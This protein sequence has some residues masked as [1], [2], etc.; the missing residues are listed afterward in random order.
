M[1]KKDWK[2]QLLRVKQLAD[3]NLGRSEK[4][5][6]LTDDLQLLER[7]INQIKDAW[8]MIVKK[9]QACLI[10]HSGEAEKRLR[11][12]PEYAFSSCLG[13]LAVAFNNETVLGKT[14]GLCSEAQMFLA[15]GSVHYTMDIEA[16]VIQP[17]QVLVDRDIPAILKLR[18]QLAN[19]TLDMDSAKS[20]YQAL[21][22]QSQNAS[23]SVRL[24]A[25]REEF[26]E[27]EAKVEHCKDVLATEMYSFFAREEELC[28]MLLSLLES[29]LVFHQHSI[30]ALDRL[31]PLVKEEIEMMAT[32]PVFGCS[33]EEHLRHSKR[34]VASVIEECAV[35][36]IR[37]GLDV[38]G[39]FRIAPAA[40]KVKKL[41]AAFDAN[42]VDLV[43][44]DDIHCFSAAL[45]HYLRELPEP[46]MTF[47]LYDEWLQAS[48]RPS[49]ERLNALWVVIDKLPKINCLHLRYLIKFLTKVTE[50]SDV[51]KMN[52]SNLGIVIGPNLLW[53]PGDSRRDIHH[54][55]SVALIVE[56]LISSSEWFFPG[57]L[58]FSPAGNL[59]LNPTISSSTDIVSQK[60]QVKIAFLKDSPNDN[61]SA[62]LPTSHSASSLLEQ[63]VVS[64]SKLT[65]SM[66][67]NVFKPP[68]KV[69]KTAP[70]DRKSVV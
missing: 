1:S 20:R 44:C 69:K 67:S 5:E 32:R 10:P 7:Q 34:D 58:D 31:I 65:E 50:R 38:E 24:D 52:A 40:S 35:T 60:S 70:A 41:K 53:P 27:A 66:S 30:D 43:E 33:L 63:S 51:N 36:I 42:M 3:Q 9:L 25:S 68:R 45:K 21:C 2:K 57:D 28:K 18:R 54:T 48:Q 26:E 22:R 62:T 12:L 11:K 4:S 14:F 64:E 49:D 46:I 19:M 59:A 55:A 17:A 16:K 6:V 23:S 29:Q 47:E 39:I 37:K 13:D 15:K 56:I 8:Q 61:S